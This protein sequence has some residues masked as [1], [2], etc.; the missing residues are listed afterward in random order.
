MVRYFNIDTGKSFKKISFQDYLYPVNML[1][2]ISR[3]E[4]NPNHKFALIIDNKPFLK[5]AEKIE[6]NNKPKV[7]GC[8]TIEY[9]DLYNYKYIML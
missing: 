2:D 5:F 6:L 4:G 3:F 8:V 1:K 9:V 7:D